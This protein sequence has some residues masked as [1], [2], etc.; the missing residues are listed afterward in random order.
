MKTVDD[1]KDWWRWYS[2]RFMAAAAAFPVIWAQIPPDA[3][4]LIP[5]SV[6]PWIP[7]ALI[8]AAMLG[9]VIDQPKKGGGA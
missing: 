4:A 3:K 9:R 1:A 2:M 8:I 5:E 6:E 7:V